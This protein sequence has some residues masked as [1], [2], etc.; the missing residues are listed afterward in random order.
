VLA[1]APIASIMRL[2]RSSMLEVLR[3]DYVR[4]ARAK[5]LRERAVIYRHALKNSLIPAI[6]LLG[7]LAAGLLGGAVIIEQVFAWPGVGQ[8]A[9]AAI[10]SRDYP[11]VQAD[12]LI[13]SCSFVVINLLVDL[14]YARLDPRIRYR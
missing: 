7:L 10:Y 3:Q 12:V 6:T 5:G 4:T 8:I 13:V 9:V 1:F 11:V 2:T 14:L